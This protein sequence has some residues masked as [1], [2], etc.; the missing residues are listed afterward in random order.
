MKKL[1]E[2]VEPIH[3]FFSRAQALGQAFGPVLFQ[4]PPHWPVDRKRLETFLDALPPRH[5][6][7]IEFREPSWYADDVLTLLKNHRVPVCLHD[8]HGSESGKINDSHFVYARFHG[9]QKYSGRYPDGVLD[10]WADWFAD[11]LSAGTSIYAYFNNDIGGHA[12]RDAIRLRDKIRDRAP[13]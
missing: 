2:P 4:L 7:V 6:H 8:M 12:P 9:P 3:R 10:D 13:S 11:R 1:K 5:Q